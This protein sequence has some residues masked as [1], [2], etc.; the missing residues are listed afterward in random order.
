VWTDGTPC[1]IPVELIDFQ[2]T[3]DV[4]QKQIVLNWQTANELNNKG[5][6]VQKQMRYGSDWQTL[7]FVNA[8]GKATWYDFVDKTP[9]LLNYYRLRQMDFDGKE[10]F[11]KVVSVAT[12]GAKTLKIYPTLVTNGILNVEGIE[13]TEGGIFA[14]YN[15]LGQMI[16][17]GKTSAQIDVSSLPQGCFI[18]KMGLEQ[19]Q[20]L[21]Q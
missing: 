6:E 17:S 10:T 20:F 12:N 11:S 15:L 2:G 13:N 8:I 14:I 9:F 7:G 21:K 19:V 3:Y 1:I 4:P 18:L 16:L 5:F